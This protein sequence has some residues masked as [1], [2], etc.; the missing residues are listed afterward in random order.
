MIA[1]LHAGGVVGPGEA[2]SAWTLD[3][4]ITLPL[5]A[6]GAAYV[7]GRRRMPHGSDAGRRASLAFQAGF[8][9]L[10]LALVSPIDA[11]GEALFSVHMVQH[12]LLVLVAAPLLVMGRTLEVCLWVLSPE[13]RRAL[14]VGWQRSWGRRAFAL[15]TWGPA[16]WSVHAAALWVWHAPVLYQAAL[17]S[18]LVHTVEHASFL[19]TAV[20]FWWVPVRWATRG[21]RG[22]GAGIV[23]VFTTALQ[24][25]ALGA[26]IT[27]A[28]IAWYP[29]HQAG[30]EAWGLRLIEDQQLA[31]LVMWLPGGLVYLAA[32]GALLVG[33]LRAAGA[34]ARL[35]ERSLDLAGSA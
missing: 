25:G 2:W 20:L 31:G 1:L 10:L 16:A 14:V 18:D 32:A 9:A 3:P 34:R 33:L 22:H 15:L 7:L 6:L 24:A 12:M 26:I 11:L 28:E 4:V 8:G 21:R 29:A 35:R 19:G 27:F 17:A 30:V 13:R 5:A 23:Y